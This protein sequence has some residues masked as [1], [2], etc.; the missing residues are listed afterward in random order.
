MASN[1]FSPI[2]LI[3]VLIRLSICFRLDEKLFSLYV[4]QFFSAPPPRLK[5]SIL[6]KSF[7]FVGGV[8]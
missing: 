6:S 4:S 5:L 3:R 1:G 7:A 2:S 8:E